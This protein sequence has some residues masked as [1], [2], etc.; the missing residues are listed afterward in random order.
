MR[1]TLSG[2]E[3]CSR[4]VKE[5]SSANRRRRTT[6]IVPAQ[7]RHGVEQPREAKEG[8]QAGQDVSGGAEQE[9]KHKSNV[10][11]QRADPIMDGMIG[12]RADEAQ[13]VTI[14]GKLGDDQESRRLF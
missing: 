6:M 13:V 2:C 9:E 1:S 7:V 12:R 8:K 3:R 11:T 4:P 5:T 14:E 10:R